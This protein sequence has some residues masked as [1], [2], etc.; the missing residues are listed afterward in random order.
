MLLYNTLHKYKL[1]SGECLEMSLSAD[2]AI[3]FNASSGSCMHRTSRGTEPAST[4]AWAS[5][6]GRRGRGN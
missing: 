2:A 4:T 5:S 6:G 3:L 1:T